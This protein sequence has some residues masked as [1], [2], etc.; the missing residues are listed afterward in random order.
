MNEVTEGFVPRV[1][2]V[3]KFSFTCLLL[4]FT[5]RKEKMFSFTLFSSVRIVL[6]WFYQLIF[7]FGKFST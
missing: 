2:H 5:S 1:D 6:D 3:S 7:Y 4:F